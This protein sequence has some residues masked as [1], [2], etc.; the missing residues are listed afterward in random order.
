VSELRFNNKERYHMSIAKNARC[1]QIMR[2]VENG[3]F[4]FN[5]KFKGYNPA[6][7]VDRPSW[8]YRPRVK[9]Y[10]QPLNKGKA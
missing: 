6:T 5:S 10:A 2:D 8:D 9:I 7:E 3:K 1:S 4:V